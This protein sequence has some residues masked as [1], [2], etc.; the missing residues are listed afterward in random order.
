MNEGSV[1]YLELL[2]DIGDDASVANAIV[3]LPW[4]SWVHAVEAIWVGR[5]NTVLA[6]GILLDDGRAES[7]SRGR[8]REAALALWSRWS[9]WKHAGSVSDAAGR[10]DEC[11]SHF[12]GYTD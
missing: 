3:E 9:A 5:V 4:L 2:A 12:G 8:E 11:V 7:W 10:E 6:D 1:T